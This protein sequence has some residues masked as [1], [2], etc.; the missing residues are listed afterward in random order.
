MKI[1]LWGAG[2]TFYKVMKDFDTERH[3]IEFIIDSDRRKACCYIWGIPVRHYSD[4]CP[5]DVDAIIITTA[6]VREVEETINREFP[7]IQTPVFK[8]MDHFLA[9]EY[10]NVSHQKIADEPLYKMLEKNKFQLETDKRL[11]YLETY[12]R[13]FSRYRGTDVVF[14]EIGVYQGGSLKLWKEYFGKDC[15][16]IGVD[17]NAECEKYKEEQIEIEIGL[18][19]STLFWNYIKKKYPKVDVVLDDGGHTMK[20]Q[21]T[22]FTELFPHLSEKG[23]YMCED[24]FTSYWPAWGGAW[25]NTSTFVEFSKNL[26]DH[27]NTRFAPAEPFWNAGLTKGIKSVC[28][29]EGI[30]VMEKDITS[31]KI[32]NK[33]LSS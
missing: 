11:Q 15:T 16:I 17:I 14:M 5:S 25:G 33:L 2:N 19:E 9:Y 1:A 30:I 18:Q 22:T 7:D 28:F 13:Y 31:K 4:I 29:H 26:I 20:Q 24:V 21:I 12:E 23:V 6:F 32:D 10:V 8:D 3:T 27:M